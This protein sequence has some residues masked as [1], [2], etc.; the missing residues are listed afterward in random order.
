MR[1]FSPVSEMK[2]R[3]KIVGMSSGAKVEKQSKRGE[4]PNFLTFAYHR[5]KEERRDC[6]NRANPINRAHVKRPFEAQN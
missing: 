6:G 2:K 1:N 5:G 3:P 4:T